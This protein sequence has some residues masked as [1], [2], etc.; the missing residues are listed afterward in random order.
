LRPTKSKEKWNSLDDIV[1]IVLVENH[2]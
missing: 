1:S 2:S